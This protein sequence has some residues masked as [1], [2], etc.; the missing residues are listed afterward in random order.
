MTKV[1]ALKKML[2]AFGYGSN[3][4]EYSGNTVATVLKEFAVKAECAT[5]TSDIRSYN[6]TDILKHI[7]DNKGSEEH[8][9]F[10]LTITDTNVTVTVKRKNKTITAGSDI[11]YNGDVLTITAVGD[12]GYDVT[13]LTVNS[14]D[15]ESGDKVTVNGHNIAIVGSGTKQT[16][17]LERTATDC[18]IAVT[19]GGVSVSDGEDVISYGDEIVITATAGSEKAMS[20]LKVN[21]EDFTSGETFTVKGDVAI[22]GVAE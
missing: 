14:E 18:T 11:L 20:S 2:V 21:G 15:I 16:F 7:A 13:T 9:P 5:K 19:K 8:E 17:N 3:V 10:D 6:I 22:I 4:S 12:E 1:D